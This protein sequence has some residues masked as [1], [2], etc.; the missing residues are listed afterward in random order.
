[1]TKQIRECYIW[2]GWMHRHMDWWI[3]GVDWMIEI[4][5]RWMD[6]NIEG[7]RCWWVLYVVDR[8]G[9]SV[10][11]QFLG[12]DERGPLWEQGAVCQ[13][14]P[15]LLH[16]DQEW[17]DQPSS[18]HFTHTPHTPH[19][20][21]LSLSLS[22]VLLNTASKGKRRPSLC[23][24]A[25]VCVCPLRHSFRDTG[26]NMDDRIQGCERD[27]CH[28]SVEHNTRTSAEFDDDRDTCVC[29][30]VCVYWRRGWISWKCVHNSPQN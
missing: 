16:P 19:T 9:G 28:L 21:N 22:S 4:W 30:C 1:M 6:V 12:E 15:D 5:K 13:T 17:V 27:E 8:T 25:S 18:S 11:R 3:T 24:C 23:A 2:F 29:V 20:L 26:P 14:H 7:W 10:W